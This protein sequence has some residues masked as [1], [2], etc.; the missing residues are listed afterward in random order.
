[1]NNNNNIFVINDDGTAEIPSTR[2][3]IITGLNSKYQYIIYNDSNPNDEKIVLY[4]VISRLSYSSNNE[5]IK[6]KAINIFRN[7]PD[8]TY[9]INFRYTDVV[10]EDLKSNILYGTYRNYKNIFYKENRNNPYK[11][12]VVYI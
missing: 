9:G 5:S 10:T 7:R 4:V 2:L 1:M 8:L 11:T 12:E 3:Y 6:Q